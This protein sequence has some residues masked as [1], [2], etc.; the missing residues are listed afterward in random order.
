MSI[1]E[2]K[3]VKSNMFAFCI[4]AVAIITDQLVKYWAQY[5]L[6]LMPGGTIDVLPGVFRLNYIINRGAAFGILQNH[7]TLFLVI[8]SLAVLVMGYLLISRRHKWPLM[9]RVALSLMIAGALGNFIDR[10]AYGY[11]RDMFDFYFVNFAVFNVADMCVTFAATLLIIYVLFFDRKSSKT[12][13]PQKAVDPK[14]A[15]DE[16]AGE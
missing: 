13:D 9:V 14:K 12:V 5:T 10:A 7:R 1:D 2:E 6:A 11:V 16:E 8:T 15:I 4:I 3:R